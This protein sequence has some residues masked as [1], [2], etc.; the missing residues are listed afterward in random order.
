MLKSTYF[1]ERTRVSDIRSGESPKAPISVPLYVAVLRAQRLSRNST[2]V[3]GKY[4]PPRRRL[5]SE[6][7][8]KRDGGITPYGQLYQGQYGFSL[9]SPSEGEQGA[10]C[11]R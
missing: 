5:E 2:L 9:P 8:Q 6:T 10:K 4:W 3:N 7:Y 11:M 1:G